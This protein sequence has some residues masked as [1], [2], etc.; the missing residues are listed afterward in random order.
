[1]TRDEL[2]F[3]VTDVRVRFGQLLEHVESAM[4]HAILERNRKLE[5]IVALTRELLDAMPRC[6]Q[7][8]ELATHSD[9]MG[10]GRRCGLHR[11]RW[12]LPFQ[13]AEAQTELVA[14]LREME[15]RA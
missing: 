15:E 10:H 7:C 12:W 14:A 6:E 9:P 8:N 13:R 3:A 11:E 1:M 4:P 2:N 5:A